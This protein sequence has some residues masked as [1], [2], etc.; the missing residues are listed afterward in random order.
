VSP[1]LRALLARIILVAGVVG[2]GAVLAPRLPRDQSLVIRMGSRQVTRVTGV[3]TGEGDS[4]PTV[5]FSQNFPGAS[6]RTV[7]HEFSAPNGTYIVV[8]TFTD[9]PVTPMTEAHGVAAPNQPETT[10]ER[11]VSL[12]GGEVTVS[13]D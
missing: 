12:V 10:F 4:E 11:R 7:R 8:I 2:V 6:P 13:P 3:V 5:G 9:K 1:K